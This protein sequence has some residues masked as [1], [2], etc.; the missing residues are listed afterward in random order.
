MKT[1][2]L[3][4]VMLLIFQISYT[5]IDFSEHV[6]STNAHS[7]RD[8]YAAD[9][10]GDGDMDILSASYSSHKLS[11]Y[12]NTDGEG[13]FG[14]EQII[15][16]NTLGKFIFAA[17]LD[18]D[19]DIDVISASGGTSFVAWY[20]NTDGQ[21]NFGPQQ[22]IQGYSSV[23]SIYVS[24]ID[25]DGD[26]DIIAASEFSCFDPFSRIAWYENDGLG[27]F[28]SPKD[29]LVFFA[30]QPASVYASD[31]DGDGDMDVLSAIGGEDSIS[32]FENLDGQG[33]FGPRQIITLNAAFA[34]S[35]Y[36]SDINGDGD[37]DVISAS[38]GDNKIAWY[39]N[40]DGQGTFS[41][42][43]IITTAAFGAN[44]V[45][46]SDID[47]DSDMDILVAAASIDSIAW[48]EN[49]DGLGNFGFLQYITFNADGAWSVYAIDIDGDTDID[50]LSASRLDNTIAWY[51]NL[52][53]LGVNQNSLIDFVVYPIP[54]TDILTIHSGI[55]IIEILVYDNL[56]HLVLQSK[57]QNQINISKL[58]HGVYY[59]KIEDINGDFGIKKIQKE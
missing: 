45:Y 24:D 22:V 23:W 48:L 16:T 34:T 13:T 11:W 53:I 9:L 1:K 4:L 38:S 3:A 37:I 6:I 33:N 31:L 58:Q 29:I 27:N 44:S 25:G 55:N 8:V 12:E 7:A 19:G 43:K 18:G 59:L 30:T 39:E 40:L 14:S 15:A 21:G 47:G 56:G 57:Y 35:V 20:E 2:L 32:W 50:V 49:L 52:R 28:S 5:Q 36:A 26:M 46:A 51:E 54:A 17:D 42:Q 41:S 10:D